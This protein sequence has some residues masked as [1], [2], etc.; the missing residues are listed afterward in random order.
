MVNNKT[1]REVP[2]RVA[3]PLS[4]ESVKKKRNHLL[5]SMVGA[6]VIATGLVMMPQATFA[7]GTEQPPAIVQREAVAAPSAS[8]TE[9]STASASETTSASASETS[10]ASASEVSS[11]STTEA[12]SAS[13]TEA[14][15]SAPEASTASTSEASSNAS[16]AP[17]TE[18][19][20]DAG[21][22]TTATGEKKDE[23]AEA[24]VDNS[25]SVSD[26][27]PEAQVAKAPEAAP[28]ETA[29]TP[30]EGLEIGKEQPPEAQKVPGEVT[31]PNY[32]E[33]EKIIKDYDGN[34][35]YKETDLQP[36]D[37]NQTLDKT[38]EKAEKDGFKFELKNPG[39][40]SPS[41][42]EYGYEIT[43]DKKTGQR[44]Y[45]K[46]TVTDSGLIPVNPGDKPMINQGDKLTAESP[47]VT[48]KP[49]EDTEITKSG[50][51]L[52]LNYV[53]S[54]ETLKH[55]NN[56]DN[57]STSFGFKDKYTQDNPNN[58]FF[59]G[60]FGITYKVNPWPNENDALEELKLNK[61]N[62]NSNAKYFVQ[63]QDIDTGIKVDN[64][65]DSAKERL[66]GQVY[67]PITGGIVP[68]AGAYIGDNGNIFIKMPDGAINK[69]GTINKDSIFYKDSNYKGI[70]NL[71][72][73]FFARPRTKAEFENVANMGGEWDKGTYVE[74]GAGSATIS[75]KGND[76]TI[77]KQG[78]D[79]YDHYN[80][81]GDFKLNL[82]DTRYYDQ[83]FIDGNNEDTSKNTS[84]GVKPGKPFEVKIY[85]PKDSLSPYIKSADDMNKANKNGEASGQVILDFINKANEGKEDKDQWKVTLT[86]GDIGRFTITPPKSAKAGDFVA[87]PVE[88]TYT[89]GS[90]DTHWFHFVVQESD[91]N[92]PEYFAKIGFKGDT[93]TSTPTIPDDE[94]SQKKN[95]PKTYEL[96]PGT[97]KDSAGNVW[98]NITVD[99]DTGVVTAVVP[100][101]ADIK[102]GENLY[103]DV[104]VNYKDEFGIE[105]EET[106]KAQFIARP[107]YKQEV[108]KEFTS[109][110]PFETKV[111][112]DEN[113]EAGKVVKT[114]GVVGE[115]KT[116]FKQ[117]VIN[118]EKGI[119][120]EKG[121]FVAGKESA[122][123]TTVTEKQDAVIRI[124]T[125]PAETTVDIPRG[126]E[127]ELDYT[128]K[129][130]D[131]EVVEEGNDGLVTITTTR[132]PETGEI[133]VTKTVTTEAKN[134]KIKIPAKTEGTV[135][136]TDE[137][138]FGYTVEF[139]PDFYKNYPDAKDNYKVVTEGKVGTN[140]K[141]WTIVNSQ[142]VGDYALEKT[143]P[144]N[145]VIK[146]GQ[147]DYTGTVTN[148]VT[149]E[150]PYTVKVVQNPNLDA[151]KTNV[152][153]EG[154]AGS[155]TY[156]YSGDIVNGK[157]KD[158][159]NF[160]EKELTDKYVEPTE[161]IIEI[162]TKPVENEKSVESIVGVDVEWEFDP[163]KDIGVI[164][165]GDLIP[166][167]VTTKTVNKYNPETGEIET[168]QETVVEKGKRK[169]VAGTRAY[170]GEFEEVNKDVIPYETE[171]VFDN[172]LK[173]GEKVVNQAGENGLKTTTTLHKIVNG[174]V[175]E[176][177]DPV[178]EVN[179]KA[180]KQIIRVGTMTN[181]D[182]TYTEKIPFDY[183]ITYD[184]NLKAGEYVV[185]VRGEEGSKTT[186]WTIENSKVVEGSAS[187]IDQKQPTKAKIRVGNKD[188]TGEVKHTEHFEIPFEVEVRYNNELPAG[189]SNEIQKGVKGS[190]DVEYK[191]DFKNGELVGEMTKTE[192]NK[193]DSVKHIIEIGTKVET[194]ENNYSKNVE[195][196]IEYVYDNTKDKDLVETGELTPGKV[197]TKVVD[198]YNPETGK[199]EQTTEEVVTKAKQKVIVGTKDFTGTY[200]YKK[201]CPIP[202]EVEVIEDDTLSK[203]EK[204]VD[205]EGKAGSKTTSYEQDIKNGEAVG[206]ARKTGEEV[207]EQPTKHI[208][209]VGTKSLTGTNE[210]VVDKAIPYETKVIYDENL[211]A[212]TRV[213]DNEGKDGKERV[214]T[215][216]T[217]KD[218]DIQVDS[219]GKV[220]EEK[221][222]RV[223]RVGIKP[224]TKVE[225]IPH[226]T[227]YTH[228]PELKAGDVK[229]IS[230]GTP[231]KVT[232]TTTFN[233]ET[234]ELETK[235]ER[236]EPT[237]AKYEYGSKTEGE[238]KY[239]SEIPF[240]VEIIKDNKLDAG[241]YEIVQ[242]GEVGQKE[243][244]VVIENSKEV[245]G[246]TTENIIKK[247]V[248]KI[249]RVGTKP[250]ENMCPVPGLNP[251]NPSNPG[252]DNPNNPVNPNPSTPNN[253]VNP[254]PS[255]P[256][257]PVNPDPSTPNNPVNPNPSTPNNPV[258][259]N[260]STPNN[261]VNPNPST[262][263]NPANPNPST[264]NNP[265]N[266]NPS[267]PNNPVN[268]NPSTSNN[269]ANS[270]PSTSD[271][272]ENSN[273]SWNNAVGGMKA[274]PA[275][276]GRAK[277]DGK[278]PQT[279]DP[280]IAA[281]TGLA[282]LASGLLVG[283]ERLKRRK[284]D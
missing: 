17:A 34:N 110:V 155:R 248:K 115:T 242:E 207:T 95:Q 42:T 66:V 1:N 13:T 255:T 277:D 81:I 55:I 154:K 156:E 147:K 268:P 18:K 7:Q 68:G 218:G 215:T 30:K 158:G 281:P 29:T 253:P 2:D 172:T 205:Q 41:K 182:H 83:S 131:P 177:G 275:V 169:V 195:V 61:N 279:F 181:G 222:D 87:V 161:H 73:K 228:N 191:Q 119:I 141:T 282:A 132:D 27:A 273:P 236:T 114:E 211:D 117:V 33:D 280:G 51:Q 8:A 276:S 37:T 22:Q 166:G 69:D 23:A 278:A 151:G 88:Y 210:K 187:V 212:G 72:V 266:P 139:D 53:A 32:A 157:L 168:T 201:T 10:S 163:N 135:V 259:P 45:T 80:L 227:T 47:D 230:D 263:S 234:G 75:H 184:P 229:K 116:T 26:A 274:S 63:G 46:V 89:N 270:N 38:D 149:K 188:F 202:F 97:Y 79:R 103:V 192:S 232:I 198:K 128:R 193:K 251:G 185:D 59:R 186:K 146:V 283:L 64:I 265:A 239:K 76:V 180:V 123:V 246:K 258:N 107:K 57:D 67:N 262:P 14:S 190:Y 206:E 109:K 56:K 104:K 48:Y 5:K 6:S 260:P 173:A 24:A 153:Q 90:K 129:D 233:K 118:G 121:N 235:V 269:P 11:S 225:E 36:G 98:D 254:N 145:A 165:V 175:V 60:N 152:K 174:K 261:P 142:I 284:R 40:D 102:G 126:L 250:T 100:E 134:K 130:G 264:P 137:I 120:D 200:E 160:T 196:E 179:K 106:V 93:L 238:F 243:T 12:T 159:T 171:I 204:V 86:D 25:A 4:N 223:V 272:R 138:P 209:R 77:D 49:E 50:R 125:K 99:K 257:N 111:I 21:A 144:I 240:E 78:I 122:E 244:T 19:A 245:E 136:D 54:E 28:A 176:S 214:T 3:L 216:I 267:T 127:Y 167:K 16:E 224:V 213:V 9:A 39:A 58:K 101:S 70:Q 85:E 96:I 252:G 241:T 247:P 162:G 150:V 62:Y 74:T 164:E 143:E 124:G 189:T 108:T 199:V 271:T 140:K 82:D 15:S 197:E 183:E 20:A 148:T 170:N 112:Y 94:A 231:G 217:S 194:P 208:V 113:L 71:D 221:E 52:N 91:N 219:A 84:S 44:T 92:R 256:N 237:N 220:I 133:K 105:K 65:D 203:G 35:R 43:I 249:V 31:E 226:D 178:T